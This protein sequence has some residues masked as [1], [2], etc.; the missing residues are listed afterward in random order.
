MPNS[1]A[2]LPNPQSFDVSRDEVA[3]DRV[4]GLMWQR[5]LVE[6][7]ASFAGA[8]EACES[9]TLAGYDDWR[10]PSRIELVSILDWSEFNPRSTLRVSGDTQRLVLDL[11]PGDGR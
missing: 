6:Q 7:P 4:T 10:L 11:V 2:G 8:R 9:L 5:K 3:V 1:A